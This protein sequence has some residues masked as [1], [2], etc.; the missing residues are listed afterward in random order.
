MGRLVKNIILVFSIPAVLITVFTYGFMAARKDSST[1][2][3]RDLEGDRSVLNDIVISGYLED[4]YHGRYFELKNG[5][6]ESSFLYYQHQDDIAGLKKPQNLVNAVIHNDFVYYYQFEYKIS[7]GAKT[8]EQPEKNMPAANNPSLR[9]ST[10]FTDSIDI[11][12]KITKRPA[13]FT[14]PDFDLASLYLDPGLRYEN[15]SMD[16]E[17]YRYLSD[18]EYQSVYTDYSLNPAPSRTLPNWQ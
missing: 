8:E 1:F 15:S 2:F 13:D 5:T 18:V 6:L 17:F 10:V 11:H 9:R 14:A 16:I 12:V 4:R 3:L 7:P